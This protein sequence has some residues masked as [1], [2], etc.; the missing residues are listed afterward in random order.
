MAGIALKGQRDFVFIRVP[1]EVLLKR[2]MFEEKKLHL[3]WVS[4]FTMLQIIS[5]LRQTHSFD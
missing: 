2:K 5:G 1:P 3:M 4:F